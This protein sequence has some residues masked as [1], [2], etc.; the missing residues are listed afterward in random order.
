M[1]IRHPIPEL[2]HFQNLTLKIRVKGH[3]WGHSSKSQCGS[4][5]LSTH[6]PFILCETGIPFL[7]YDFFENLTLKIKGQGHGWGHSSKS[8]CGSNILSIH[9]P[10]VPCQSALLFLRY[11]IFIIWPWKSRVKVKWPWCCTT[12]GL[13]NSI[14][15]RMVQIH[16][17]V[18]EIW[19][20]QSQAQV[21]PHLTSFWP[22]LGKWANNYDSAQLQVQTSPWNFKWGQSIQRFQRYAFHKV[23]TQFVP[24]LTSF[25]PMGKPISL[26]YLL[27]YPP[28]IATVMKLTSFCSKY[29]PVS[30][31]KSLGESQ[32]WN[33]VFQG[34][35]WSRVKDF[36]KIHGF[37][38]FGYRRYI[39]HWII[40]RAH[41]FRNL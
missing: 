14:E 28:Q 27:I 12:T 41:K 25:W 35:I 21:L 16:P 34:N 8:Q 31:T 5:I 13:D 10:F 22:I 1:W 33:M 17:G 6:I 9:I 39:L 24:N 7:S 23:W 20:P 38:H 40:N 26:G 3:G 32:E 2:Q 15:L 19:V 4:N 11:S 18:S 36:K 30:H 29:N 37:A